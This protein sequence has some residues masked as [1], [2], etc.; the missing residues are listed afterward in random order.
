METIR[1]TE[2]AVDL[3]QKL[4]EDFGAPESLESLEPLFFKPKPTEKAKENEI[5]VLSNDCILESAASSFEWPKMVQEETTVDMAVPQ[6]L[7]ENVCPTEFAADDNIRTM[8]VAEP[9]LNDEYLDFVNEKIKPFATSS[10]MAF[11]LVLPDA[12]KNEKQS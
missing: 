6:P 10:G 4:C 11:A 3:E 8:E 2:N 9:I 1:D 5:L 12:L 7:Q